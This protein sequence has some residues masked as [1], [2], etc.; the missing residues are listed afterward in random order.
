[1]VVLKMRGES[2]DIFAWAGLKLRI[3]LILA[4]QVARIIGISH[5]CP[6]D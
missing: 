5:R 6:A 2:Q 1:M 3:L 4:S